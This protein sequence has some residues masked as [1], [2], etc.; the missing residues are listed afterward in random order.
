M[1]RSCKFHSIGLLLSLAIQLVAFSDSSEI[2]LPDLLKESMEK[3]RTLPL[4]GIL[5]FRRGISSGTPSEFVTKVKLCRC[6]N[7][8]ERMEVLEPTFLQ[9]S[10][11][12]KTYNQLWVT[13]LP[14][15]TIDQLPR[16][17]RFHL[18]F[19][20]FNDITASID[21][22]HFDLLLENYNLLLENADT[23][24]GRSTQVLY[25]QS[26]NLKTYRKRP[27]LRIWVDKEIRIPLK[28]EQYDND[29]K[30]V[31]TVQFEQLA[32]EETADCQT[33]TDGLIEIPPPR[34]PQDQ[35]ALSLNFTPLQP[36]SIPIG[37][38]EVDTHIF[39][40]DEDIVYE[41]QYWDGL[42]RFSTFQRLQRPEEQDAQSHEPEE[43]KYKVKKFKDKD[44]YYRELKG[45]RIV[46]MGD[47][48][49]GAMSYMLSSLEVCNPSPET[50]SDSQSDQK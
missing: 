45:I 22:R 39:K 12:V 23:V 50:K 26:K 20:I 30:W 25:I 11:M 28:C 33:G 40:R 5:S 46:A 3:A 36:K 6:V 43:E 49:S 2:P 8:R 7:S 42:A 18:W 35:A 29:S 1:I 38:K 31:E 15:E 44:I 14:K 21:L 4:Q 17:I 19:R 41:T 10:L 32:F 37:F 16:E 48:E 34:P 47:L 13:P 24:A 9:N 27:S